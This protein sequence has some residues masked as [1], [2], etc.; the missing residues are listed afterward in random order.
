[1]R[2]RRIGV[3]L[4]MLA[5]LSS[6]A[7]CAAQPAAQVSAPADQASG[8]SAS[9]PQALQA[10]KPAGAPAAGSAAAP[11]A[12]SAA[13]PPQQEQAPSPVDLGQRLVQRNAALALQVEDVAAAATQA[14]QLAESYKDGFVVSSVVRDEGGRPAA[15]VVI[16]IPSERLDEAMAKLKEKVVRLQSEQVTSQDITDQFIDTDARL[17]NLRLTEQRYQDLLAQAR[18]VDDILRIEQQLNNIRTQIDQTQGRLNFLKQS[19]ATSTITLELRLPPAA[20]TPPPNDWSVQPVVRSA[21]AALQSALQLA[22]SFAIFGVIFTPIWLP[23]ALILRWLIRRAERQRR[24]ATA[25][26][27]APPAAAAGA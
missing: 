7:A 22:V 2:R 19:A 10:P 8:A 14:K 3:L 24:L 1:M 25:A 23:L 6:L 12:R 26:A 18:T 11:A 9:A 13:A 15:T 4:A 17:K 21:L 20:Q 27:A 5:V 16:R